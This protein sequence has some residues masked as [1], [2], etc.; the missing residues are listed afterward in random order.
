MTGTYDDIVHECL[1][2]GAFLS[3]GRL[4]LDRACS[5]IKRRKQVDGAMLFIGAFQS[6]DEKPSIQA[7][8]RKAGYV[9]TSS[10]KIVRGLNQ[11]V[12]S[13]AQVQPDHVRRLGCKLRVGADAP[14]TE[15]PQLDAFLAQ[16]APYHI[17]ILQ[18]YLSSRRSSR[19]SSLRSSRRSSRRISLR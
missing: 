8:E 7:L 3:L 18:Y 10:G 9:C 13:A 19:L 1:E 14:R 15:A 17:V 2:V 6:V 12:F 4:R 5:H 16:D 11:C